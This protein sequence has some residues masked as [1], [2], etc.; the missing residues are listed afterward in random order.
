MNSVNEFGVD[1]ATE[2]LRRSRHPLRKSIKFFYLKNIL[3]DVIDET[4]DFGCGA[5]QLLACLPAGSVGLEVNSHLVDALRKT[6]LNAQ[7]YDPE[8]DFLFQDFIYGHYKTFVMA[9]VLEHFEDA[10]KVLQKIL[11]SCSRIGI[12]RAIIVVPGFKG[13]QSDKTHKTF[14]NRRYLTEHGL[15]N[16]EG[17]AIRDA[18]YFPIDIE[19]VGDYFIFHEF[20]LVY[21]RVSIQS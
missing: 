19:S 13:F 2:Q 11:R 1:Y 3:R 20:K 16:C 21:D 9:H 10:D 17:Y 5:G 6:G 14:V 8:D 7:R 12:E 15:L 18:S 4:I